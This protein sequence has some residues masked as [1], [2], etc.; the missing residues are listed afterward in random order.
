MMIKRPPAKAILG[1]RLEPSHMNL[2]HYLSEQQA[3]AAL[4]FMDDPSRVGLP[5]MALDVMTSLLID[6]WPVQEYEREVGAPARS[7]RPLLAQA[8]DTYIA[9]DRQA[10]A[11]GRARRMPTL[12]DEIR[13][14]KRPRDEVIEDLAARIEWLTCTYEGADDEVAQV[15]AGLGV[16]KQVAHLFLIL[17]QSAGVT[18]PRERIMNRLYA[19]KPDDADP[20]IVDVLVCKLRKKLPSDTRIENVRGVG[21]RLVSS[22][23]AAQGIPLPPSLPRS[24]A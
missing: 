18:L 23:S 12:R 1:A 21:Y 20:K 8:L 22:R 9:L 17:K 15:M 11:A 13:A 2:V 19:N 16:S 10:L 24:D 7:A 6:K 4:Q 14:E 3:E 5:P